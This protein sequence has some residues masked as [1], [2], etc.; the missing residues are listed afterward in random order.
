MSTTID[1]LDIE[2]KTSAGGAATNIGALVNSLSK[3]NKNANLTKVCNNLDK[4]AASLDRV[5]ASSSG[6]SAIREV[7]AAV[8]SLETVSKPAGLNSA[9][10]SLKKIPEVVSGLDASTL[11][12]FTTKMQA[13]AD[14]LNP[15]AEKINTVA[16]GFSKLPSQVSKTVTATNRMAKASK[17]AA[18]EQTKHN[19]TLNKFSINLAASI[20]NIR[21]AIQA[22]RSLVN[23]AKEVIGAAIEWDGIQF[24]FGRAFGENAD[25]VYEHMQR[26]SQKMK[27]NLQ[28]LMQYSSMFGSLLSGFGL[29]QEKTKVIS[30]G[31]TE[32]TYD[33]WAA[34]NDRYKTINDAYEAVRSAI[35]G[36]IEPI[37][38][39]GIALTQASMQEYL[40]SIGLAHIKVA[41]LS[42]AQKAQVRYATMV[43]AAMNQG[44][45]GTYAREMG[46]AEG[47]VRTLSQQLKELAQAIGMLFIPILSAVVPYI[48]AF[49]RALYNAIEAVA[50]FLH[51]PFFQVDWDNSTNGVEDVA[52]ALGEAADAAAEFK[53]Y[54]MGIDELNIIT[55]TTNGASTS[56]WEGLSNLTTLWDDTVFESASQQVDDLVPKME[57][58]L[59]LALLIGSAFAMWKIVPAFITGLN[60]IKAVLA[61][62][63]GNT[64]AVS[65]LTFMGKEKLAAQVAL[66]AAA[67]SKV[68]AAVVAAF[69]AIVSAGKAV[70]AFFGGLGATL[71]VVIGVIAAVASA[72]YF[73]YKNWD[74]VVQTVKEFYELNIAPT[75]E[76]I[77]E[78]L[79]KVKE[80][81]VGVKDA[82][83]NLLPPELR[84][85]VERFIEQIGKILR[86]LNLLEFA[87]WLVEGIGGAVV[88]I[89]GGGLAGA[90]SALA[91]VIENLVQI[92]SGAV[93]I[94]SGNLE[95][96]FARLA[97]DDEGAKKAW[98]KMVR[99]LKEVILGSC[100]LLTEP[101]SKFK[102]AI[103]SWLDSLLSNTTSWWGDV[104][105]WFAADVLPVFTTAYWA[106]VFSSVKD[107]LGNALDKAKK[108]ASEKWNGIENWF[109]QTVAPKF[110]SSRWAGIFGKVN[111]ALG[112]VLDKANVTAAD[113]WGAMLGW[114]GNNVNP[115]FKLIV[116]KG[117][118]GV[119][120]EA[121]GI[122]LD[123]VRATMA[124]RW[125]AIKTWYEENIA[126]LF[127]REYWK[128]VFSSIPSGLGDALS[129]AWEAIEEFFSDMKKKISEAMS[130]SGGLFAASG[131]AGLTVSYDTDVGKAKTKVYEM[132]GL[133]GWPTLSWGAYASGGFP[134]AGEMFVAREAGPEL[135]GRIGHRNAVANNDQIV[136]GIAGGVQLANEN[137][138]A[139]I[140]AMARQVVNA[141]ETN[142]G[143]V[144]MDGEKVSSQITGRQNRSTKMYGKT[145]QAT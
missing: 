58:V 43:N 114:F 139:A 120:C 112:A 74:K 36:E 79:T 18:S 46:T 47:A 38:N 5:K 144:Y 1:S 92:F 10:N 141:I 89:I 93:Q 101:L 23:A 14:A 71:G 26:I 125:E 136:D 80:A 70:V 82:F 25:E 143:D 124:A 94:I 98:L 39:A 75:F 77:K 78:H 97:G 118:F 76:T 55:T 49:V 13:L 132:L 31:L 84:E 20:V 30:T 65:A 87:L 15:L 106:N 91:S 102:S 29:D 131:S 137:V 123:T 68:K 19:K 145:L 88:G 99:G 104:K 135:V 44:I 95:F 100:G 134:A 110:A 117:L 48:T 9:I 121:L 96:I 56:D 62:I 126:P 12:E 85:A 52:G 133:E 28:E 129:E 60:T 59:K 34:N 142:G 16:A 66:W 83:L 11:S 54:T 67:V 4:L 72:V 103:V 64:A 115:R 32:L 111:D 130:D 21:S 33:I 51:I 108:T 17:S 41:Q 3:L 105:R 35:T 86:E 63:A 50:N 37:R 128:S 140:Y 109:N 127:T 116:W 57:K 6:L 81:L 69:G 7:A 22:M 122:E 40:D 45:I 138:V 61:G 53:K 107:A 113:K 2:I 27:I 42:E 24:R 119:I 8:K 90:I 73:L